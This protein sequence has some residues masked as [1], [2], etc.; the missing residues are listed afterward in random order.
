MFDTIKENPK[1]TIWG[2]LTILSEVLRNNPDLVGFLPD[3]IKGYVLG[4]CS[5]I[6]AITVSIYARD[7]KAPKAE[8]VPEKP[9]DK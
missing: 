6:C 4:T 9:L 8:V 1:T 3:T 2:I 7:R 5:I